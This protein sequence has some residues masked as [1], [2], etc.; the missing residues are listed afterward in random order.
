MT[1]SVATIMFI[2]QTTRRK[3]APGAHDGVR[4][5][6][7]IIV[8]ITVS[9]ANKAPSS[10]NGPRRPIPEED[11]TILSSIRVDCE[12]VKARSKNLGSKRKGTRIMPRSR[13]CLDNMLPATSSNAIARLSPVSVDTGSER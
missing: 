6:D 10:K 12:G 2:E 8:A 5:A 13:R 11:E 4:T 1:L 7:C 9:T 3:A